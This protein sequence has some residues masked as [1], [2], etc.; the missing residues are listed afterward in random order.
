MVICQGNITIKCNFSERE[1]LRNEMAV[2]AECVRSP[3]TAGKLVLS[4][5]FMALCYQLSH[6]QICNIRKS[7]L[8]KEE[9]SSLLLGDCENVS[10]RWA[11]VFLIHQGEV[12]CLSAEGK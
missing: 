9:E 12:C 6:C 5:L 1:P 4:R 3:C 2:L 10:Q 7:I 11:E 8:G